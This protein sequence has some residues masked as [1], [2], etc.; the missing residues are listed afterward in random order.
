MPAQVH[1]LKI[2]RSEARWASVSWKL[3]TAP[4]SSH[5]TQLVISVYRNGYLLRSVVIS[6]R[7]QFNITGLDPST[8][9]RVGITTIDVSRRSTKVIYQR[10][11]TKEAGT[12][13]G[14]FSIVIYYHFHISLR[15]Q[16]SYLIYALL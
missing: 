3:P 6:Q 8:E 16:V 12:T 5:V 14:F 11:K 1:E 10:F 7:T 13:C 4:S 9:Y 15:F 2:T